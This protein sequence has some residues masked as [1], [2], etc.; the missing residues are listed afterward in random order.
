MNDKILLA[1]FMGMLSGD[2]WLSIKTKKAG[3]K[4]Y[5]VEFCNTELQIVTKFRDLFFKIFNVQGNIHPRKRPNRKEIFQ[6]SSYFKESFFRLSKLGF[7]IGVK[8]DVLK[9]LD[10]IKSGSKEEKLAFLFGLYLTDGCLKKDSLIYF[11]LGSKTFL[12]EVAELISELSGSKKIVKT[13]VQREKFYSYQL[14]LNKE[15]TRMILSA[16]IA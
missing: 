4:S 14:G 8:R 16:R 1:L 2:G 5:S 6:F 13:Y 7:P 9:I 15:E 10:F 3:Y 12:R 11:H